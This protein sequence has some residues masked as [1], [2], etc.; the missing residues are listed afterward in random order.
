[1]GSAKG[2]SVIILTWNGIDLVKE[3][4]RQVIP[5]VEK[6]A[7]PHEIVLV[8]NGSNDGTV[9]YV[10]NEWP[11]VHVRAFDSNLGFGPANNRAVEQAAYDTLLFLNNDLV[12]EENFIEHLVAWLDVQDVFAVAPKM[13]RW[14]KETIDDGLRY[15]D[16][17]SGLFDVKLDTDREKVE[18]P[19]TV[20][21]FCGACFLCKKELFLELGGF[22][23]LYTPYAWEDLDL[24]YRAWKRGY[25]VIYEPRSICY[26]KREAT[27]RSL[28][29]NIFF[30][31]LMWRNKFIFMWKNIT[32]TPFFKEHIRLLPWKLLKFLF[33]GRWRY[34][35]GFVRA[36]GH[37]PAIIAHRKRERQFAKKND[38]TVLAESYAMIER[39]GN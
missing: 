9:E 25:R 29:S 34:V 10:K 8:D 1:M 6:W 23:E 24:G 19:H 36:I 13:L 37:L 7:I 38:A 17:Y 33:N 39:G 28:F 21:F 5:A 32:Y 3:C 20:T 30:V 27:T 11:F 14:D 18:Q 12:L 35:L 31:S 22:D 15:A 4:V 16:F 26:H 2:I